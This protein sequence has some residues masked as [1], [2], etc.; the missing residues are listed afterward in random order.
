[1][2]SDADNDME[3]GRCSCRADNLTAAQAILLYKVS[4]S[5][6]RCELIPG[7]QG[8]FTCSLCLLV[9]FCISRTILQSIMLLSYALV[10]LQF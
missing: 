8:S 4:M 2:R 6:D 3:E 7:L 1:M 9:Y 10:M 5:D